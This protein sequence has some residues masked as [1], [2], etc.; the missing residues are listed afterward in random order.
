MFLLVFTTAKAITDSMPDFCHFP[1]FPGVSID[2]TYAASGAWN[3]LYGLDPANG[4]WRIRLIDRIDN[5]VIDGQLV[6]ASIQF[7]DTI[8]QNRSFKTG[9]KNSYGI[10][11]GTFRK[12]IQT[13]RY[14]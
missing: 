14:R 6:Y 8:R 4:N 2:G 3:T 10:P 7:I 1:P 5:G 11:L 12:E 13:S 9:H